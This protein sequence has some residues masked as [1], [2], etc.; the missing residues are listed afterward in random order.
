MIDLTGKTAIMMCGMNA[1]A[2]GVAQRLSTAGTEIIF[3]HLPDDEA[4]AKSLASEISA[5]NK[6]ARTTPISFLNPE[7]LKLQI[8]P[9]G[10]AD[11]VV[12]TPSYFAFSAFMESSP[13]HWDDAL[14]RN[15]EQAVYVSQAAARHLIVQGKGGRIIFLT[16][17]AALMPLI[18]RSAVG[19]A[20]A[21]LRALAKMAAVDLAPHGIT[22][23][24]VA[25][26]WVEAEWTAK[27]LTPEG[28]AYL[29]EDI[30]VGRIST[31]Q[32][33][34]DVCCFLASD[35]AAYVTGVTIP[36]DGGYLLTRA[37]VGKLPYPP[38]GG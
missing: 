14:A 31:P 9:L 23:N 34:G 20:L 30:P 28:R 32:E 37:K 38:E 10:P 19:T 16:S 7:Q 15:Y 25:A 27:F 11:I 22:V 18:N 13:S 29:E 36:V 3:A 2:G 6:P 26:A 33:I 4:Q 35:L 24:T 8:A 12:I 21:A 5:G 17:V 1:L